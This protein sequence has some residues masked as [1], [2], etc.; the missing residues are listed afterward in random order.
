MLRQL[1][2]VFLAL[3]FAT[4][5]FA[6]D[7]RWFRAESPN[8][9]VYGDRDDDQVRRAAQLLED[10]DSVLRMLTGAPQ[11]PAETKLDVYLLRGSRGLREVWPT[12]SAGVGGFYIAGNEQIAVFAR[13]DDRTGLDGNEILFHEYAHH[14]MLHYFPHAY[15]RWYIEGWA[16]WVS[17]VEIA[18]QE[19]HARV[20]TP[21]ALRSSW[22]IYDTTIPIEHLLEPDRRPHRDRDFQSQFYAYAWFATMFVQNNAELRP[23]LQRYITALGD[24][25]DEIEAFEPAF[26]M[27]PGQ[28]ESRLR[29]FRRARVRTFQLA[30]PNA[31]SN[32]SVSRLPSAADDLLLPLARLRAMSGRQTPEELEAMAQAASRSPGHPMAQIVLARVALLQDDF[33]TA[34]PYLDALLAADENNA[35]ARFLLA[36]IMLEQANDSEDPY[37]AVQEARRQLVRG[38]RANPNHFPTLYYYAATFTGGASPMSQQQLD[39]LGRALELAPQADG[40]R[41]LLARE[42]I[43]SEEYDVAVRILRPLIYAPHGG[44]DAARARV[45]FDAAQRREQISQQAEEEAAAAAEQPADE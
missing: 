20:G 37:A 44:G 9:V 10:F 14:F 45:L 2:V 35:E 40:I 22:L 5:A 27:T 11:V 38:F 6:Q 23:G 34:R 32:I 33:M 4:P 7:G 15:P 8:F 18:T 41:L 29:A 24:G 17:T 19:R 31:I 43:I 39:V 26:G 28:F 3:A 13:Y 21:S 42:L 30:L 12:M 36:R 16:D 1:G 25:A